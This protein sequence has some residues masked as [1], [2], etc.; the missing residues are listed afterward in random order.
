MLTPSNVCRAVRIALLAIAVLYLTLGA[1]LDLTK[2]Q[3]IARVILGAA[4]AFYVGR[5]MIPLSLDRGDSQWVSTTYTSYGCTVQHVDNTLALALLTPLDERYQ[6][7][8]R[9]WAWIWYKD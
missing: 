2:T 3:D 8:R 6:T 9:F 4:L 5:A 7:A 1:N